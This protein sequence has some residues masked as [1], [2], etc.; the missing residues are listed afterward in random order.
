MFNKILRQSRLEY[1]Y[2]CI[3]YYFI[4]VAST[5]LESIDETIDPCENF[6]QFACGMQIKNTKIPKDG[7]LIVFRVYMLK[8][9]TE[10]I[11]YNTTQP[12]LKIPFIGWTLGCR[13]PLSVEDRSI[14]FFH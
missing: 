8:L 4:F 5:L 6:Y 10:F 1:L 11:L 7:K 14:V 3:K 12:T 2:A 9:D 13:M